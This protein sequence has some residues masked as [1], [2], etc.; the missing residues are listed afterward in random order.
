MFITSFSRREPPLTSL[1]TIV[2]SPPGWA[3][4]ASST[5]AEARA[6]VR[7]EV[8]LPVGIPGIDHAGQLVRTD[9]EVTLPLKSL[10]DSGLPSVAQLLARLREGLK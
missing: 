8:Y 2:L 7:A 5:R 6:E 9:G 10:R 1:P 4:A 3:N